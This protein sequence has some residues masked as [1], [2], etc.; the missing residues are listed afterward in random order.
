MHS[1]AHFRR[2]QIVLLS[3]LALIVV[4]KGWAGFRES[5]FPPSAVQDAFYVAVFFGF[6]QIV[7]FVVVATAK[8]TRKFG[9]TAALIAWFA[10]LALYAGVIRMP[11]HVYHHFEGPIALLG[12]IVGLV[13][14]FFATSG[15]QARNDRS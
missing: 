13:V 10:V 15:R 9:V 1:M 2:W 11:G 14:A 6:P 3:A 5:R 4:L 7:W 12:E 8:D